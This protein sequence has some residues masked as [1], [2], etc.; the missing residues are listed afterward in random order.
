[1]TAIEWVMLASLLI[2]LFGSLGSFAIFAARKLIKIELAVD[3]M[4]LVEQDITTIKEE[5]AL[6][7]HTLSECVNCT[8]LA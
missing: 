7:K 2:G 3:R 8:S 1:M 4:L 6:I 5:Q